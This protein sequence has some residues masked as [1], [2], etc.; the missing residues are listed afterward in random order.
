LV[1]HPRLEGTAMILELVMAV[2][3]VKVMTL[4]F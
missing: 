2:F 1:L 4:A 3:V